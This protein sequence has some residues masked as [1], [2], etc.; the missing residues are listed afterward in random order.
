M[1]SRLD[2]VFEAAVKA[3][4]VPAVAAIAL[5]RSGDVLFKGVYN[6]PDMHDPAAIRMTPRTPVMIWSCTKLVTSVAALQLLEQGKLHL[7]DPVEKYVPGIANI[8]VL[9]GFQPDGEPIL[10]APKTKATVLHLMTHTAG[11]SYDVFSKDTLQ[12]RTQVGQTPSEYVAVGALKNFETPFNFDPGTQYQYGINTDWLGFVVEA[13]TGMPLN[14]YVERNI[15]KPLGMND[16]G[17]H[18]KEGASQ[19]VEYLRGEDGGLTAAPAIACATAPER[20]GGGHYLYSTLD[21]Y[22]TFLL[23]ILNNGTHPASKTEILK[24]ETATEYLFQDQIHKICSNKGT[25]VIET[26]IPMLSSE[27]EFLPGVEK[28]WSCGMMLSLEDS[29]QGRS[30]G[31]GSW[32]GLG[33]L[34]YWLDPKKGKLGFVM[35]AILPFMD[36]EVLYLF[37]ELERAVYGHESAS[38]ADGIGEISA[39]FRCRGTQ[40]DTYALPYV[41]RFMCRNDCAIWSMMIPSFSPA[42]RMPTANEACLELRKCSIFPTAFLRHPL[43]QFGFPM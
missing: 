2:P 33:N 21:D 25:G 8:Q 18:V 4:K 15:L 37:E 20:F 11:F 39:S 42:L 41:D 31:S 6:S 1:E 29:P 23:T 24:A 12:W 30:A 3:K 16:S 43:R 34:Y 38:G 32:A 13:V 26:A 27:G 22:S 9:E 35:S 40:S 5:D 10:R 28:G 36:K 14:E 7:E 17:S 19:L